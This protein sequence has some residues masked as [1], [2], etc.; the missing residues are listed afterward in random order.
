MNTY[1]RLKIHVVWRK[2]SAF[3]YKLIVILET[4]HKSLKSELKPSFTV[5]NNH[6]NLCLQIENSEWLLCKEQNASFKCR[7]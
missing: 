6:L 5:Y 7:Y 3:R 2:F 1:L 4:N